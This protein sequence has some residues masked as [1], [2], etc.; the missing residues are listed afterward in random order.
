MK[1]KLYT[2]PVNDAFN[3]DCECP[4]C[5]IYNKLESD[6]LD[7]TLGPSYMEEDIRQITDKEGFCQ[8]HILKLYKKQ[9]NLGLANILKT[10]LFN[11]IKDIEAISKKPY[12]KNGIFKKNTLS[13]LSEY[14]KTHN[15]SC[16][17][18]NKVNTTFDRYIATILH[19]YKNDTTFQDKFLNSKGFCLKHYEM[20]YTTAINKLTGNL[21]DSFIADIHKVTI[22]NLKRVDADLDWYIDK[23]DYRYKDAPWKNSKDA[24][25]RT[26]IKISSEVPKD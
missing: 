11:R 6:A 20:L 1:E 26:I 8:K 24:I 12:T 13:P 17:I 5:Y 18:C 15:E 19:L 2:I 3:K 23:F 21:L 4:L 7:F 10:H 14:I 9:N 22:A 25:E 16:F